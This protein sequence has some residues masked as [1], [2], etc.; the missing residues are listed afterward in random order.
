MVLK[1]IRQ[2][3]SSRAG[4]IFP[5]ARINNKLKKFPTSC[6][7]V[8]KTSAVYVTAVLEYLTGI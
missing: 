8:T 4:L 3:Q 2:S 7:R 6:K 5:V 1:R